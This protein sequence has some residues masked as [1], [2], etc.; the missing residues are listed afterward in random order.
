[1]TKKIAINATELDYSNVKPEED[2]RQY[3]EPYPPGWIHPPQNPS[4][5]ST[6]EGAT[7]SDYDA[8]VGQQILPNENFWR[9]HANHE[10][11]RKLIK[12]KSDTERKLLA[13]TFQL[14]LDLSCPKLDDCIPRGSILE[15]V[16]RYFFEFTD[17]PR[18]LPFFYVMQYLLATLLQRGVQIHKGKQI[19]L[20]D[21]WVIVV[22]RSASGKTLSQK[23]LN[24]AMGGEVKLFS[25]AK[26]SLQFLT[27]LRDQRLGLYIRDEFAQ[28]LKD[29]A[30][31]QS[32]QNVRDYLL[33]TYDNGNI[34]H[35]S[36][37][38]SVKVDKSAISILGYTPTKT[39]RNHLTLEMLLD[40]FAQ[41]F[42][43]CVAEQDD[44][45]I[46]GDYDFD[47]LSDRITPFWNKINSMHIHAV[48]KVSNDARIVFNR[49]VN[50]IVTMARL[51]DI[52]D[53]FSR[54]LA[55]TTY[56][57]GLA[58]HI[59]SGKEDDMIDAEDLKQAAQLVALHL[60]NLRKILDLYET[61]TKNR[62]ASNHVS[63]SNSNDP[64]LEAR[65]EVIDRGNQ[66]PLPDKLI[67]VK[68]FL[69]KRKAVNAAP[70]TI[71]KLQ[72]SIRALRGSAHETRAFA[73]KA[74]DED[75]SLKPFVNL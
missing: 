43:Y 75:P 3:Y 45:P 51:D 19:I 10:G 55:F 47:H 28:F 41:R 26:T 30:K 71:S 9:R 35:T 70:I 14:D 73:I 58:Y 13:E 50:D 11:F 74:I 7:Q 27:N 22:A 36:T 52:D 65:D 29:I 16:D 21:L 15:A 64:E 62:S 53:S 46:V 72:S 39:L 38:G 4:F 69:E 63:S 56:K 20:P 49:V 24:L 40:G 68:A 54:R 44:R 25:D 48:Y 23:Q 60:L 2:G 59:L 5:R 57:Y 18:E 37:A 31:D 61:N 8:V 1:M 67:L 17:S 33:R 12:D 6:L 42:S 32:M 66:L 34:E